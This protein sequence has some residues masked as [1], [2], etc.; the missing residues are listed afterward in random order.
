[1]LARE[2][3]ASARTTVTRFNLWLLRSCLT[4]RLSRLLR[5][6]CAI[7]HICLPAHVCRTAHRLNACV[8]TRSQ[9]CDV[10]IFLFL[11]QKFPDRDDRQR[12]YIF[13]RAEAACWRCGALTKP[14]C[15]PV[16]PLGP[17]FRAAPVHVPRNKRNCKFGFTAAA[18]VVCLVSV[19]TMSCRAPRPLAAFRGKSV[20]QP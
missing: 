8:P 16:K 3:S 14:L 19:T 18:G 1:M 7:P 10:H 11:R 17:R 6:V 20:N 13:A 2:R 15:S 9:H 12:Y 4:K 5:S